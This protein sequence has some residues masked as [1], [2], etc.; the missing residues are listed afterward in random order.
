MTLSRAFLSVCM[1]VSLMLASLMKARP[2]NCCLVSYHVE[3]V[4]RFYIKLKL[5]H[6]R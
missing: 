4:M 3:S 5:N 6:I 1:D 2:Y